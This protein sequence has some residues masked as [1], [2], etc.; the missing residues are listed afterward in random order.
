[1]RTGRAVYVATVVI[2]ALALSNHTLADPS[3]GVKDI[4]SFA[5]CINN[6][7]AQGNK[8]DISNAVQC[9]PKGCKITVTMSSESAQKACS[10]AGCQLPRVIFSCPTNNQ[11]TLRLR[12]S[13][14]LCPLDSQ[15]KATGSSEACEGT[16]DNPCPC[17]PPADGGSFGTAT[18]PFVLKETEGS[19]MVNGAQA[20][21]LPKPVFGNGDIVLCEDGKA[22]DESC[23]KSDVISCFNSGGGGG[24]YR[25]LSDSDTGDNFANTV[26]FPTHKFFN[27]P[28]SG[29]IAY[30]ACTGNECNVFRISGDP[31]YGTDRVEIGEDTAKVTGNKGTMKMGDIHIPPGENFQSVNDFLSVVV[32]GSTE[33]SKGCNEAGCHANASPGNAQAGEPQLS[34]PIDPFTIDAIFNLPPFVIATDEP[35][36]GLVPD[37]KKQDA[38]GMPLKSAPDNTPVK[39]QS[40]DDICTCIQNN[41]GNIKTQANDPNLKEDQRNPELEVDVVLNLCKAL[42]A[43]SKPPAG[44]ACGL[45]QPGDPTGLACGGLLGGGKFLGFL[46]NPLAVSALQVDISG[47]IVRGDLGSFRFL[48]FDGDM[49]AYNYLTRTL[50]SSI[51]FSSLQGNVID[52]GGS[53][54]IN[55]TG[56]GTALVSTPFSPNG[57]LTSVTF[58]IIKNDT[59]VS[60][61]IRNSANAL[62]AGG[63]GDPAFPERAGLELNIS[64]P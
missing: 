6:N 1:M 27:E 9:I 37:D 15:S 21:P 58:Q 18:D 2:T 33:G 50:I 16:A 42:A 13:F 54:F 8:A 48:D 12:P 10:L 44:K 7:I 52:S 36:R 35:N 46:N 62:L 38:D 30:I 22:P 63:A 32:A 29:N 55:V 26:L 49:S 14:L 53:E 28:A 56:A 61:S 19:D 41:K 25:F 57:V 47:D 24:V 3:D 23:K 17:A 31:L 59:N 60:F 43:Y 5:D 45:A 11:N 4:Q 64:A 39:N 20:L 40:L 51:D 34:K